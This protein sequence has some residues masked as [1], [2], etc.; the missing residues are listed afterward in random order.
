M[1]YLVK[2][3]HEI[4]FI[5]IA[6]SNDEIDYLYPILETIKDGKFLSTKYQPKTIRLAKPPHVIIFANYQP[7]ID[8]LSKDR[9]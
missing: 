4:I 1:L 2:E 7:K 6:R 5:N 3:Y 8:K 9:W